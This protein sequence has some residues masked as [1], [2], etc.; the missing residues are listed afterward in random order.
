MTGIVVKKTF[1]CI[2]GKKYKHHSSLCKHKTT[3][4]YNEPAQN[5]IITHCL[6]TNK[7]ILDAIS[8]MQTQQL[9]LMRTLIKNK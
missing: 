7:T 6:D 8:L 3:C 9:E 4:S 5:Y 1:I 2:C